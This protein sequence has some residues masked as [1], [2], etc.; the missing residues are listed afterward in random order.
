VHYQPIYSLAS[1]ELVSWESLLRWHHPTRGLVPPD[2]FIPIAEETG[3]IV[4]LG[5][6][7]LEQACHQARAWQDLTGDRTLAMSVNVSVRQFQAPGLV[8][9]VA[10]ILAQTGLPPET[11][12]L[13]ITES[14][15]MRNPQGASST[16]RA[17]KDLGI[18]LAIDDFGTG[19]SSLAYLKRLPVDTLK[20]DRSFI[21]GLGSDPQDSAIV[22][23]VLALART[24]ELS[25]TA[26][27]IETLAQQTQLVMLG[28]EF[29]Q[30]YLLGTP[31]PAESAETE[32]LRLLGSSAASA[33]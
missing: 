17:L 20:I 28:C 10:R 25:V 32:L 13:E 27:G 7:V 33:A 5:Q 30:G 31:L 9:E 23:S 19:Y 29:G 11:L 3:L 8:A 4:A 21:D 18:Q 26:E 12:R 22:R 2:V 6:W 1:G 14:A 16:L 24:L 15:M